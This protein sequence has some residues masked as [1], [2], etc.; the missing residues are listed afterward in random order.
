VGDREAAFDAIANGDA[1]RLRELLAGDP[2]L[3]QA[4]GDDDVSLVRRA[5]YAMRDDMV[6]AILAEG[7]ELDVYDAAALGDVERVRELCN[8]DPQRIKALA[9]D[10]FS[11][12]HL[13]AF[14]GGGETVRALL[15]LGAD[16]NAEA[17][18]AM[19]VRPLHSAA[20]RCDADAVGRLLEAG[21]DPNTQQRGGFTALHA[22]ASAGDAALVQVLLQSGADASVET[23]EG[24]TALQVAEERGHAE[25]AD[26]LREQ[27]D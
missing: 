25:V 23:D 2:S 22:G 10:G 18:N 17:A 5:R 7:P 3:A 21:A 6:D 1:D 8:E 16:A 9:P 20:A 27:Q 19:R 13:A 4:R 24:K 11:A 15:D 26:L 14:F 12:L